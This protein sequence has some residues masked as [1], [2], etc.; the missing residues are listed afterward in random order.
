MVANSLDLELVLGFLLHE[1]FL[2]LHVSGEEVLCVGQGVPQLRDLDLCN[3][4]EHLLVLDG[5]GVAV[6]VERDADGLSQLSWVPSQWV[7]GP[8]SSLECLLII[9][10]YATYWL[11]EGVSM[12]LA[13]LAA[14]VTCLVFRGRALSVHFL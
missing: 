7:L 1:G 9:L 2:L 11:L 13:T 6:V 12:A 4:A 10:I 14:P 5:H 3:V 8:R